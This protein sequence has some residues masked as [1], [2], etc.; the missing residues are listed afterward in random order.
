MC[1]PAR[2]NGISLNRVSHIPLPNF[3]ANLTEEIYENAD[4]KY[5]K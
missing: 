2:G 4:E 5:N 3:K 1:L